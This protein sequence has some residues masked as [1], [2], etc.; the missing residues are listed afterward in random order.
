MDPCTVQLTLY[1]FA[2]VGPQSV[3][4]ILAADVVNDVNNEV[5]LS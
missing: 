3:Q 5:M 2:Y 4:H 1:Q